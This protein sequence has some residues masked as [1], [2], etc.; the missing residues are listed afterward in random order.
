M[1][2][3]QTL[4]RKTSEFAQSLKTT[5]ETIEGGCMR[6]FTM[7]AG[8]ALACSLL[9]GSYAVAQT[10]TPM[11]APVVSSET[12]TAPAAETPTTAPM[13]SGKEKRLASAAPVGK[14]DDGMIHG[15]KKS[16]M[17]HLAT[18]PSYGTLSAKNITSF[19]TEDEAMKAGYHKAKNCK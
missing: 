13:K 19:A 1:W 5:A 9:V 15:N 18:C 11:K 4:L 3:M 14:V 8:Y 6:K 7:F 12:T 10:V 2:Q 16:H 17:Y